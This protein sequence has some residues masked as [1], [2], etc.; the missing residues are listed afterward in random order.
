MRFEEKSISAAVFKRKQAK[1]EDELAAAHESLAETEA[2]LQLNAEHLRLALELAEDAAGVYKA[3]DK[4]LK[5]GY[6]QASFK[7]LYVMPEWDEEQAQMAVSITRAE[8]TE[9]YALLLADDFAEGVLA[10]AESIKAQ[11]IAGKSSKSPW[12]LIRK[13]HEARFGPRTD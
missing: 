7:K 4:Q 10:D 1:L 6:N 2:A 9:P 8:L 11:G 3:G 5:R 13:L 12:P